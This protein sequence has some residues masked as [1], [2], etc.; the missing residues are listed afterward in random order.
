MPW[1]TSLDLRLTKGLRLGGMHWTA[2]A[3][4]R[5]LLNLTNI[6]T[7]F[8]ETGDVSNDKYRDIYIAPE[9]D[10][11]E[12]EA[13]AFL[14]SVDG[15]NRIVLPTDCN[16]WGGGAVNCLLIKGA[17]ARFGN[18]DGFYTETEY[19]SALN[20]EYDLFN[21]PYTFY[22]AGQQIRLGLELRF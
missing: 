11:L 17:E 8:A 9:V 12:S 7:L 6:T 19:M 2:Y 10:R 15:E 20:A 13:G 3:D 22:A 1:V 18:G 16:Q 4:F 5:N 14:Q 21:A